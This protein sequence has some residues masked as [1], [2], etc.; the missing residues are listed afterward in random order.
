MVSA[1]FDIDGLVIWK[2]VKQWLRLL[3]KGHVEVAEFSFD[4]CLEATMKKAFEILEDMKETSLELTEKVIDT[5]KAGIDAA[6][7]TPWLHGDDDDD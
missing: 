3:H 7:E 5:F 1:S 4:D 6:L 2:R